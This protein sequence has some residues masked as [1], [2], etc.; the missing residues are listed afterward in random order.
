MAKRNGADNEENDESSMG[1]RSCHVLTCVQ[2]HTGTTTAE[3]L[4]LKPVA[5]FDLKIRVAIRVSPIAV[6][7]CYGWER[8]VMTVPNSNGG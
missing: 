8:A 1:D 5:V 3:T 7:T 4:S 6:D 2:L